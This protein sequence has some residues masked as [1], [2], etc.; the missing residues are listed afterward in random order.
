MVGDKER[1]GVCNP[2]RVLSPDLSRGGTP[3]SGFCFQNREEYIS[4]V[5]KPPG[6]WDL[7]MVITISVLG[8]QAK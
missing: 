6:L 7:D 5:C 4:V 1:S 8:K 2:E 3:V